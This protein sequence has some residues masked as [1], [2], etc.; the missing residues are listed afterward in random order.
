MVG[1]AAAIACDRTAVVRARKEGHAHQQGRAH[2]ASDQPE[3]S[4]DLDTALLGFQV[5]WTWAGS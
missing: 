5:T 4:R 2:I 1:R 3:A